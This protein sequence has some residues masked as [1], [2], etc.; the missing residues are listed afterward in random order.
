MAAFALA[1]GSVVGACAEVDRP[2]CYAGDFIGCTCG[3]DTRGYAACTEASAYG[4][5]VCDGRTPGLDASPDDA[6]GD[7]GPDVVD[8]GRKGFLGACVKNDDCEVGLF[9][10]DFPSRGTFCTR[11]CTT[12]TV[13]TDCPPPSPGCNKDG[14][15]RAP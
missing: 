8:A 15:C 10:K 2:R 14:I 5:C 12:A 9:C 13:A 1:A 3:G 4:A 7:A 6:S 11:A